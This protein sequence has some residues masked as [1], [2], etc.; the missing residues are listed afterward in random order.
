[1]RAILHKQIHKFLSLQREPQKLVDSVILSILTVFFLSENA[2]LNLVAL[3][4]GV[5]FECHLAGFLL[6][7]LQRQAKS[8]SNL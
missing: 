6:Y 2:P 8:L 5:L 4:S 3:Y 7:V 1:M